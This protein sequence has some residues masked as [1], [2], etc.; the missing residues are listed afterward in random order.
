MRTNGRASGGFNAL[1]AEREPALRDQAARALKMMGLNTFEARS[2]AEAI[3]VFGSVEVHAMIIDVNLPQIGGLEAVRVI[4]TFAKVPPFLLLARHVTRSLQ[5]AAIESRAV[6]ILQ[7]PADLALLS[8]ML[9][10]VLDRS[11]GSGWAV[12]GGE[13]GGERL[14]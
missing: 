2:G 12:G 13:G 1:I 8:E 11:Y 14:F 6:S 4:R 9:A 7:T 5:A 10:A 3:D